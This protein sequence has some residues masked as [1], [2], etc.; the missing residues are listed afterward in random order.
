MSEAPKPFTWV[1]CSR[2]FILVIF[3][4]QSIGLLRCH[5]FQDLADPLDSE[6]HLCGEGL[7]ELF[8]K[9][10]LLL[11]LSRLLK[12]RYELSCSISSPW[13]LYAYQFAHVYLLKVL[14]INL[15]VF[16]ERLL[17]LSL[18][19][20]PLSMKT[21]ATVI[22]DVGV[23]S[24]NLREHSIPAPS[25]F[26]HHTVLSLAATASVIACCS[27]SCSRLLRLWWCQVR[28]KDPCLPCLRDGISYLLLSSHSYCNYPLF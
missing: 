15:E 9:E 26:R 11:Y 7:P 27:L 8:F 23:P 3:S 21:S 6:P 16:C 17:L 13:P 19:L 4:C 20:I 2:R 1:D 12:Q 14:I 18:N 28:G 22:A 24:L 10:V 25:L 5:S